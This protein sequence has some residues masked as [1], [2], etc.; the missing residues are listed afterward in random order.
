MDANL[1]IAKSSDQF[2][3]K[4]FP[5]MRNDLKSFCTLQIICDYL[6]NS[7]C[8]KNYIMK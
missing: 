2:I 1:Q 7:L 3:F 8:L 6:T 4:I 5:E